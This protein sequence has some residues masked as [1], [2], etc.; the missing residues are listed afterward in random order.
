M[1]KAVIIIIAMIACT[2]LSSCSSSIKET[3]PFGTDFSSVLKEAGVEPFNDDYIVQCY[4]QT[5]NIFT[6]GKI[7]DSLDSTFVS[8]ES[9]NEYGESIQN[10]FGFI[11]NNADTANKYYDYTASGGV[12][13]PTLCNDHTVWFVRES[14]GKYK[15]DIIEMFNDFDPNITFIS[16]PYLSKEQLDFQ[17]PKHT[18]EKCK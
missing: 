8:I 6:D 9:F 2:I 1:M 12:Y 4:H 3:K 7:S 16:K 13:Q 18:I 5:V 15:Q 14:G 17:V 11:F 10:G